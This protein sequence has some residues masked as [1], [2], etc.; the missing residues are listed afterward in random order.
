MHHAVDDFDAEP[1]T[2]RRV[3]I[4]GDRPVGPTGAHSRVVDDPLLAIR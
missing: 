2:V 1:R 4:R 3:T